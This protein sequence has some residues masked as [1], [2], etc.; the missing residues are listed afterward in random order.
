MRAKDLPKTITDSQGNSY[1]RKDVFEFDS[2]EYCLNY[3]NKLD[4]FNVPLLSIKGELL[5]KPIL[6]TIRLSE[7]LCTAES[8]FLDIRTEGH[9]VSEAMKK[10]IALVEENI[11]K[12]NKKVDDLIFRNIKE[13]HKE[14]WLKLADM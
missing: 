2:K 3:F 12:Y 11:G 7:N 9:N 4:E 8:K 13:R 5:I 10:L 1:F 6:V 14:A